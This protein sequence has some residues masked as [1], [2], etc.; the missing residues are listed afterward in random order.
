M[1]D[2]LMKKACITFLLASL[3]LCLCV[4]AGCTGA[5]DEGTPPAV[6]EATPATVSIEDTPVQYAEVNGVNLAYREFGEGD[7]L[8]LIDGFTGV[9]DGW[10]E[11]FISLLAGHYHVYTYDHRAMGYSGDN[12]D[13]YTIPQLADDAAGLMGALGYESMH[14]YGVSMGSMISQQLV[15]DHPDKVRKLILSSPDCFNIR[16]IQTTEDYDQFVSSYVEDPSTS[17]G[18]RKEAEAILT[19]NGTYDDLSGITKDVMLVV[20]TDDDL[21]PDAIAVQMAEQIDGSWLVRFK[22]VPHAGSYDAPVQYG[23]V[24]LTFLETDVSPL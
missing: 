18:I 17:T 12:D 1:E 4:A 19:W 2:D 11:T 7:P 23:E 10:N 24:V 14:V 21:T 3:C 22:G 20:G 13:P 5:V 9:M 8:L 15:V 16:L 6:P